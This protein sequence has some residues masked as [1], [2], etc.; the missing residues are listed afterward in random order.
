MWI[1]QR[2]RYLV[3]QLTFLEDKSGCAPSPQTP[4]YVDFTPPPVT[5]R[6]AYVSGREFRGCLT[7]QTAEYEE[8]IPHSVQCGP[9]VGGIR[10]P[11]GPIS[12]QSPK[13]ES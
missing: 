6:T 8:F 3:D 1:L 7:P 9:E 13:M 5:S 12:L 10:R 11:G 2:R 4:E